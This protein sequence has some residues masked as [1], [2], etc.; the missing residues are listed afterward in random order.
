VAQILPDVKGFPEGLSTVI[1]EKGI[2]LSGG[3]RQR[4]AIARALLLDSPILILDDAFSS[5][6]IE[7]EERILEAMESCTKGKTILLVTHRLAPL[8]RADRI[9][10]F[11]QGQVVEEGDHLSLLAR[12]GIY[13]DLYRQRELE[14]ELE[15]A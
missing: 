12:G 7:T 15:K 3:Q 8:R 2:T 1:G 11:H 4:L 9:V 14:E 5:V 13:A 6:D 10:V